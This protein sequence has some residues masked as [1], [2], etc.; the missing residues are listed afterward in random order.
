MYSLTIPGTVKIIPR[1]LCMECINLINVEIED[2]V[3]KI[4]TWAFSKCYNL[5][6]IMIPSSVKKFGK[7]VFDKCEDVTI[8]GQQGSAAESYAKSNNIRFVEWI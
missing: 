6:M 2:G 4:D 7:C 1:K 8:Y 3:E 5:Q